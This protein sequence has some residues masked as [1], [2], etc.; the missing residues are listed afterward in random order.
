M[1]ALD[2]D[3]MRGHG[4]DPEDPDLIRLD[5]D[6]RTRWPAFQFADD[7]APLQIVRTINRMLDVA[8]DPVGVTD[9]WL[10]RNSRI[11]DAPAH[12]IGTLPDEHLI[13]LARTGL[14]DT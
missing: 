10:Q 5:I 14:S 12:L 2:A 6:G 13:A 9:W 1:P 3:E 11:G 4:H 7:G 8:D